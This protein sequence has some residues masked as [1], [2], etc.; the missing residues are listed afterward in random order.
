M[1][2]Q[3]PSS[4]GKPS[5]IT[6]TKEQNLNLEDLVITKKSKCEESTNN[7]DEITQVDLHF[8]NIGLKEYT[9]DDM[10]FNVLSLHDVG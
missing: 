6:Q 9:I 3:T 2:K 7:N 4:T 1:L 8:K 5:L 10:M